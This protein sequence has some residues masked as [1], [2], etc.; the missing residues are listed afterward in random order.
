MRLGAL[1]PPTG[2]TRTGHRRRDR[3]IQLRP[4]PSDRIRRH[5]HRRGHQRRA[6]RTP[7]PS[8]EGPATPDADAPSSTG[9]PHPSAEPTT[10]G[11]H[12]TRPPP[13]HRPH[14]PKAETEVIAS[15][16]L[17]PTP[18]D[19][20]GPLLSRRTRRIRAGQPSP[21]HAVH[22]SRWPTRPMSATSFPSRYGDQPDAFGFQKGKATG[23]AARAWA[24]AQYSPGLRPEA[25]TPATGARHTHP[26]LVQAR[27][28]RP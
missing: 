24:E 3:I 2:S 14:R 8:L 22:Y 28:P 13:Y 25:S 27:Y 20:C 26:Q 10:L 17:S 23:S 19:G 11:W 4:A 16:P 21:R 15:Q 7:L 1:T 12:A 6:S 9:A 5:P 18:G